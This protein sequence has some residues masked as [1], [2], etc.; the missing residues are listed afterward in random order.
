[1]WSN[2]GDLQILKERGPSAGILT[3]SPG[4]GALHGG[5]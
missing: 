3:Q 4:G 5:L 2:S 1:M